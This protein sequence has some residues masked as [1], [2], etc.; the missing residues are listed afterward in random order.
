M[1][2]QRLKR[3]AKAKDIEEAEDGGMSYNFIYNN[4]QKLLNFKF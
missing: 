4:D 1:E 2:E 3:E